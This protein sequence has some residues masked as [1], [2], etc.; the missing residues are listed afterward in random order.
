[1]PAAYVVKKGQSLWSIAAERLGNGERYREIIELN[2][3]LRD[4]GQLET[5]M[6]LKLPAAK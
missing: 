1:M 6:E 2:P 3:Q 5:G 4:P